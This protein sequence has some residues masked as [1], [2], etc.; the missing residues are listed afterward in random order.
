MKLSFGFK[1]GWVVRKFVIADLALLSGWGLVNPI[2]A[3]FVVERI[4]GATVVT[5]G[6]AAAAYWLS[7]A[8]FQ[9][10]V[11][12]LID[13]KK[14]ERDDFAVLV[15]SLVLV[16][17][18]AFAF[19]IINQIWQLYLLQALH[20]AAFAMYTPSWSGIFSRHLDKGHEAIDWALDNTAISI[21]TGATGLVS[22]LIVIWLGYDA[23]FVLAGISSLVSAAIIFSVPKV[24]FP[25][26]VRKKGSFS[27]RDH[28][29]VSS[30]GR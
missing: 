2:F 7:K 9:L 25:K 23:L 17:F 30:V 22:G 14:G 18:S 19:T 3:I 8:I 13:R 21:A 24:I 29:P 16:A 20:A 10:P 6:I 28:K 4:Q 15:A 12:T 26:E 1:I 11:A 27:I 5:V